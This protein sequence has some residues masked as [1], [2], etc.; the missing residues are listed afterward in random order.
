M[1][2]RQINSA[3]SYRGGVRRD[4]IDGCEDGPND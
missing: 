2:E 4:G 1:D 3:H